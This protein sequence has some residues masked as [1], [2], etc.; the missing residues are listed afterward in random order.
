MLIK[1]HTQEGLLA[2]QTLRFM[3][4][5]GNAHHGVALPNNFWTLSQWTGCIAQLGLQVRQWQD[6]LDLYPRPATWLFD[7]RLHFI[8]HLERS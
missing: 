3:D 1:D 6:R 4:W 8:A 7:R 5:F 2:F